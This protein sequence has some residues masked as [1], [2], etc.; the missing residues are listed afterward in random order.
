MKQLII[1]SLIVIT[2][3][4]GCK[5]TERSFEN[6]ESKA[7]ILNKSYED[8]VKYAETHLKQ[9]GSEIGKLTANPEFVNYIHESVIKKFDDEYEVLIK[10]IQ[11]D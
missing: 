10:D 4:A 5:K 1:L 9:L 8:Q 2:I 6:G 11:N 3:T 7:T